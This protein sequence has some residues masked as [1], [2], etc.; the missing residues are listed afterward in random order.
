MTI[1]R[2]LSNEFQNNQNNTHTQKT[3]QWNFKRIRIRIEL[4]R[5]C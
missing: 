2:A 4:I 1:L 3:T 5:I